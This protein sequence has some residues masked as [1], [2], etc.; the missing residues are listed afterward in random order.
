MSL[1]D[2]NDGQAPRSSIGIR[3]KT[4]GGLAILLGML[5]AATTMLVADSWLA[6]RSAAEAEI[7]NTL[8]GDLAGAALELSLE[9]GRTNSALMASP[10]AER[11]GRL[12]IPAQRAVA[13]ARIR[14][15]L[16]WLDGHPEIL[17]GE[18]RA[19]LLTAIERVT[20]LRRQVD[21]ELEK[22]ADRRD[23]AVAAAWLPAISGLIEVIRFAIDARMAAFDLRNAA[24][25]H[26]ALLAGVLGSG[27]P[28]D[29][30]S[31]VQVGSRREAID[32]HWGRLKR[33]AKSID[34]ARLEEAVRAVGHEYFGGYAEL[35]EEITAAGLAREPYR[36]GREDYDQAVLP[37]LARIDELILTSQQIAAEML[38]SQ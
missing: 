32:L 36:I 21:I 22:P 4:L 10:L 31:A 18:V 20:E 13:D 9:R 24:G 26:S 1:Q 28:L 11:P 6:M 33:L 23:P 12:S 29:L 38:R 7:R 34:D 8:A 2:A 16:D 17:A 30:A 19:E 25:E 35:L 27:R 15:V 37:A 5:L 14:Q 3:A